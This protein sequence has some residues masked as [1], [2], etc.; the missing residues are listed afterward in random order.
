MRVIIIRTSVSAAFALLGC[1]LVVHAS[2]LVQNGDDVVRGKE[3]YNQCI[4]CHSPERHR[5]GP[6][7]CGL[8]GRNAG[9][10]EG[11]EYSSAMRESGIVWSTQTLDYFLYSPLEYM[12]GINMGIAGIKDEN[13]RMDL[14]AYLIAMNERSECE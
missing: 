3:V 10:A 4:G 12:P 11:Y 7:H 5:T 8:I 9:A 6:K 2:T 14:I 13:D 1:A